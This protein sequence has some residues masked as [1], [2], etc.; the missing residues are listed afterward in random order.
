[1]ARTVPSAGRAATR[2]WEG[3]LPSHRHAIAE[4]DG[5]RCGGANRIPTQPPLTF[6]RAAAAALRRLDGGHR[7]G[8]GRLVAVDRLDEILPDA[9][10]LVDLALDLLRDLLVLVEEGLGV[11]APLAEPLVAVGEERARL[12][13]DVVLDPEVE[14]AARGRDALAELDVELGLAERRRDLVL[15]DLDAD[16]V[17][18][19]LGAVLQR[20]DAADVQ[21]LGR[22][23]LQRAAARL[24][25]R[26]AEHDADLLADLVDED[27][28]GLCAVEV[29]GQLAHGLGHHPRLQADR[30]V[31]HLALELRS[32]RQRRHGVDRDHVDRAGAHEHVRDLERLLAVV[33]L[34]D[35][36]LVDVD[37]DVLGVQ[38]VH[39]MLRVD[40]RADAAE[41]LGL[42]QHV[43]DERRLTGRLRPVD[44]DDAAARHAADTERKV[45]RQ[46]PR[47]DGIDLDLRALVAHPHQR[48]LAELAL[49][50]GQRALQGG[51]AG[52]RARR[53][54]GVIAHGGVLLIEKVA[55]RGGGLG[56]GS[57]DRHRTEEKAAPCPN[58]NES[59]TG[60]RLTEVTALAPPATALARPCRRASPA[61]PRAARRAAGPRPPR[62][63][64][65][66][67]W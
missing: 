59:A 30:L 18:D 3:V 15:D 7:R 48:A 22:V 24:C 6:A 31:A 45:E 2:G 34:R 1:M 14:D 61:P 58:C 10:R 66:A 25:L 26:R 65:G 37:P 60:Y 29:A 5:G 41:L 51:I 42:G 67:D 63:R 52:L 53:V 9:E 57:Y 50:L 46:R 44:L 38:R 43:V 20:L 17:A 4:Q 28:E 40:E 19:R 49:D 35:Q 8:V 55:D 54:R 62:A 47:G 21:A 11:V 12:G 64:T 27:A 13:D 32:R 33:G 16:P 23:E 36:Q 39:R 56:R